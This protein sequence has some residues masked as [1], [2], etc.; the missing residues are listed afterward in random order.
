MKLQLWLY[1]AVLAAAP[2]AAHGQIQ[3]P[4]RGVSGS[5]VVVDG[6]NV[7]LKK[8][9]GTNV[10]V[11]MTPGWTVSTPRRTTS[12]ELAPGDFIGSA[13]V[14]LDEAS[15]K[16]NE[17]RIFEPGYRPEYG[18]HLIAMPATSMTH[19]TI[20]GVADTPAGRELRVVYP[21]GV[22]RLVVEPDIQVT[23]FDT[24]PRSTL[25]AGLKVG[26]VTRPGAD[27]VYRAG[28]LTLAQ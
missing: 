20:D 25:K 5:I 23:A 10:V 26:A 15:G 8:E 1:S 12:R 3:A 4:P 28:R 22:R 24:L 27:G 21:N 13:N 2:L 9:D 19:G 16:A 6:D 11:P 18:T 14:N 17:V 7:T